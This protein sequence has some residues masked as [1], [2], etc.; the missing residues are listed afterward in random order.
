ME[1]EAPYTGVE[2]LDPLEAEVY[3]S[4]APAEAGAET[5]LQAAPGGALAPIKEWAGD[6][7]YKTVQDT[8]TYTGYN[9]EWVRQKSSD[10]YYGEQL[11]FE[12]TV[13]TNSTVLDA[14]ACFSGLMVVLVAITILTG[15]KSIFRR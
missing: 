15:L 3:L 10:M 11:P 8:K 9:T 13:T 2:I 6:V 4:A 1:A 14:G 7:F 5:V 12:V